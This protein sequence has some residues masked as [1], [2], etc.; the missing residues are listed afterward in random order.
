MDIARRYFSAQEVAALECTAPERQTERFYEYWTLKE[1]Y[2]KARGLGLSVPLKRF[3]FDLDGIE[4][5][6]IRFSEG[7]GDFPD[8]W[9]FEL[10]R[11]TPSSVMAVALAGTPGELPRPRAGDARQWLL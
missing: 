6:S 8:R 4:R 9:R 11:P 1:S 2:V 7:F 3:S 10:Y 5:P